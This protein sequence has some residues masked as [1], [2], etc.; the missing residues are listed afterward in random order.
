MMVVN[1]FKVRYLNNF[2]KFNKIYQFIPS[3]YNNSLKKTKFPCKEVKNTFVFK[4]SP[5][6]LYE[7]AN[8]DFDIFI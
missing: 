3:F 8:V 4:T 1:L 6:K 2:K 7:Y 5:T